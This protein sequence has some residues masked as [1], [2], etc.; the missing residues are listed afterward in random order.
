MILQKRGE[1]SSCLLVGQALKEFAKM[2]NNATLLTFFVL[3][4]R[5][6]SLKYAIYVVK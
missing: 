5:D 1:D 3:G 6:F 2:E 4:N